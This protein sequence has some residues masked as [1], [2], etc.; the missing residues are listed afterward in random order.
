MMYAAESIPFIFYI[1]ERCGDAAG[2]SLESVMASVDTACW[3]YSTNILRPFLA[4]IEIA[5]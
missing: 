3:D 5:D 1:S 4:R 2:V